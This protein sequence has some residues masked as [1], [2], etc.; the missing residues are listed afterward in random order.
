MRMRN[1]DSPYHRL[2]ISAAAVEHNL[3]ALRSLMPDKARAAA[4]IKSDAYGHGALYLA[5][6]LRRAGAEAFAITKADEGVLLRQSGID[7][8]LWLLMGARP[9]DASKLLQYDLWAIS[10]EFELFEAL[11]AQAVA[12]GK[13]A[14]CLL[15]VDTGMNRLGMAPEDVMFF[16]DKL[17]ALPGLEIKGLVS[18]LAHGGD[19]KAPE[20]HKQVVAFNQLLKS[21]FNKGCDLSHSSLLNSGG[22]MCPPPDAYDIAGWVRLG[23]A[24]YGGLPDA[25]LKGKVSLRPAMELRSEI[26]AIKPA[27]TGSRVSYGGTYT[28]PH[29]TF[30][31]IVPVGYA[32]GYHRAMSGRA[33]VLINGAV[34]PLRGR[35]CMNM[36]IVDV[37]HI[38]PLPQLG[39]EV[40]LLGRQGER[41]ISIEDLA[42]WSGTISYE[43]MCS[44][45][46]CL[47]HH[48]LLPEHP[49]M[50]GGPR[51]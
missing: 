20:P 16:L 5:P 10:A 13:K 38:H 28:V 7:A 23:V 27:R 2:S 32:E 34:A 26:I 17:S 45:G 37:G 44:L 21:A 15:K 25:A 8:P 36:I 49:I 42:E 43:I 31:A 35:V 39:D 22:V 46:A 47:P 14:G 4:V 40:V 51:L 48:Y 6:Y 3:K 30:L 24:L 1:L 19:P 11:S 29:N 33:H 18:H 41:E 50:G 9:E 12:L